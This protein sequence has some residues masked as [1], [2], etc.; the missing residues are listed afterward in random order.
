MYKHWTQE[1]LV[2]LGGVQLL[3][4]KWF[5][6]M[7]SRLVWYY[8]TGSLSEWHWV[9]Y[10]FTKSI[11]WLLFYIFVMSILLFS[12]LPFCSFRRLLPKICT[13]THSGSYEP[14]HHRGPFTQSCMSPHRSRSHTVL[15][16][17]LLFRCH[18]QQWHTFYR[19]RV[20]ET[21]FPFMGTVEP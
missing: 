5:M 18:T 3:P 17:R 4:P 10:K 6:I 11:R 15:K 20:I 8:L 16:W 9:V 7:I 14:N 1:A 2:R 21:F 13:T 12:H 19:M